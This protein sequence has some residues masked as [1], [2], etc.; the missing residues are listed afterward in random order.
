M[1]PSLLLYLFMGAVTPATGFAGVFSVLGYW[2]LVASRHGVV[3]GRVL[4]PRFVQLLA[5]LFLILVALEAPVWR[6]PIDPK[7]PLAL[8]LF[9]GAVPALLASFALRDDSWLAA[10]HRTFRVAFVVFSTLI[11]VWGVGAGIDWQR[12][13]VLSPGLHKNAV[14][15]SYEVL[16]V[17]VILDERRPAGRLLVAGVSLACLVFVGSKTA[18]GL[19]LAAIAIALLGWWGMALV[20]VAAVATVVLFAGAPDLEGPLRTAVLR[21]IL[22]AQAWDEI[23]ASRAHFWLGRGPGTFAAAVDLSGLHG[24]RSPHNILLGFWHAYGLLGLLLFAAFFAWLL[25]RFGI[26]GS[27]FLA[28]FWLFNVHALFDVGWVKGAGFLASAA[29]GLGIAEVARRE[30]A[31][32]ADAGT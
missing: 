7:D 16:M 12:N 10:A 26:T 14:A 5:P 3:E 13:F 6:H 18:L 9:L 19:A 22:W 8:L 1:I 4:I 17:V 25:R 30:R 31:I 11:L 20:A 24:I 15:A 27:P 21:F 28:A 29:L 32:A 23:T 2:T